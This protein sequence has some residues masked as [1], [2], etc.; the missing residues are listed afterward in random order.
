MKNFPRLLLLSTY[1]ILSSTVSDDVPRVRA[2]GSN[3]Q[4]NN[5]RRARRER[6]KKE[7]QAAKKVGKC[8]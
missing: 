1:C 8:M 5:N 7:K 6:L 2:A 3:K 4:G